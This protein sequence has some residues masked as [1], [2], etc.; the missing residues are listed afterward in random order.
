MTALALAKFSVYLLTLTLAGSALR[1]FLNS[2]FAAYN[3][4]ANRLT[5]YCINF[6]LG[7]GSLILTSHLISFITHSYRLSLT[8][9]SP[10]FVLIALLEIFY[11]FKAKKDLKI[12]FSFTKVEILFLL[13]ILFFSF[14][15]YKV[16]AITHSNW[17]KKHHCITASILE[18]NLYPPR[19]P[20]DINTTIDNYHYG[21]NL[22]AGSI[23]HIC[24]LPVWYAHALELSIFAVITFVFA[25]ALINLFVDSYILSA[26]FAIFVIFFLSFQN[27]EF[28]IRHF[29]ELWG[30]GWNNFINAYMGLS[31]LVA[32]NLSTRLHYYSPNF[33]FALSFVFFYGII[34][35][36]KSFNRNPLTP[37]P[38]VFIF[39]SS[40]LAYFGEVMWHSVVLGLLIFCALRFLI[41]LITK[42]ISI[43]DFKT[44]LAKNYHYYALTLLSIVLGKVVCFT[45]SITEMNGIDQLIFQPNSTFKLTTGWGAFYQ[46]YLMGNEFH[47][48]YAIEA[49][50][51]DY[52][53]AFDF[54]VPIFSEFS[55][56]EI[57]NFVL[58]GI[59]VLLV[60]LIKQRKLDLSFMIFF[61]AFATF[62]IPFFFE[63]LQRPDEEVRFFIFA[64]PFFILFI[65]IA[66]VSLIKDRTKFFKGWGVLVLLLMALNIV[67]SV[68]LLAIGSGPHNSNLTVTPIETQFVTNF[69]K[70]HKT[71]DICLDDK[72]YIAWMPE[73]SLAGCYGIGYRLFREEATSRKTALALMNPILLRELNV[74]YIVI[75]DYAAL[76]D[77]AKQRLAIKGLFD[78]VETQPYLVYRF[79]KDIEID[80][81]LTDDLSKEYAWAIIWEKNATQ[82]EIQKDPK[83]NLLIS[84][85]RAE[86][87]N[88]V[89]EFK[90]LQG[91]SQPIVATW[92]GVQ[93]V[94]L[95][96]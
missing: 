59:I 5:S 45:K 93:A 53:Q 19:E 37:L 55:W 91:K 2:K 70:I 74:N 22:V 57:L 46:R 36:F 7:I 41:D 62:L 73:S 84:H 90:R 48:N 28:V 17:D 39:L 4:E 23:S 40:F 18:N 8:I 1:S 77:K 33:G 29:T 85:N 72:L 63:F 80:Q 49:A 95:P 76:T 35:L 60:V 42:E 68:Y 71:G 16:D 54:K 69:K 43:L 13:I 11:F 78:L 92:I 9:L 81:S 47:H 51:A 26:F 21:V 61:S 56:R 89:D 25:A 79:D 67:T 24:D 88:M 64:K 52:F 31:F 44:L 20:A 96:E 58:L 75:T 50:P 83:G 32:K 14:Q 86:L 3:F 82:I 87:N 65:I 30:M 15:Y 27:F 10:I 34:E 66:L 6:I 38:F 94:A 12:V